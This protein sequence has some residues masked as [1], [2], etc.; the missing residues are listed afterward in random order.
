MCLRQPSSA[1]PSPSLLFFLNLRLGAHAKF[2]VVLWSSH[3]H[4]APQYR[5]RPC[6]WLQGQCTSLSTSLPVWVLFVPSAVP[7]AKQRRRE[8]AAKASG[9]GNGS[10]TVV[11]RRRLAKSVAEFL[12]SKVNVSVDVQEGEATLVVKDVLRTLLCPQQLCQALHVLLRLV[13]RELQMCPTLQ[14]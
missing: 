8:S 2:S 14:A 6:S 11:P 7:Y 13:L 5:G 4:S 1:A 9:L 12:L 10:V 3:W